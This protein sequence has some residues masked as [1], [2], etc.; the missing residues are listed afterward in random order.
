MNN[1][2]YR[3]IFNKHLGRL[4]VVSE[5]TNAQGKAGSQGGSETV[6]NL[7][8]SQT[9]TGVVQYC[10]GK[11]LTLT[12][13][14]F[15]SLGTAQVAQADVQTQ[16]TAD[17]TAAKNEQATVLTTANG[18][19][20]VNIQ[21]PSAGGVSKN[22]FSQFDVGS[23][24]IILNNSRTNTQTQTAGWVEGNP[25]LARG[26]AKVIL[27]QVNSTNPS[28]LAGF[29]EIA[30][31]KAELIIANP[32]G[33]TCSGC[34]FI[35]ASRTTL[36]TGTPTLSNGNLTGFDVNGGKISITGQ[37]LTDTSNYTQL[38]SQAVN[39]NA[40]VHAKQLDVITGNNQV[41][42]ESDATNTQITTKDNNQSTGNLEHSN[43]TWKTTLVFLVFK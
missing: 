10:Y 42:Y 15:I 31:K 26:E 33:I 1:R 30:G 3:V 28:Q 24:G 34:G 21:T 11:W 6:I 7:A 43:A 20:Q 32:A 18:L 12:A 38:I 37:G 40:N 36:T 17:K 16:I 29:T 4:V 27:N 41:S 35:N 22:S 25:W 2:L 19:T 13:A 5:K 39:I 23:N 8:D 9:G 14:I